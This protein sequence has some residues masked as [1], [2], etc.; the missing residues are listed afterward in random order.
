MPTN[1][2]VPHTLVV[3]FGMIAFAYVLTWLLPAGSFETV[4]D[5]AGREVVVPGTFALRPDTPH[6]PFW[7][8][9]TVIPRGLAAGQSVIFFV[10]IIGGTLAII[11]STGAIDAAVASLLTTFGSRPALLISIG[12]LGFAAG[13]STMG[14]GTE[15]IPLAALLL[16]LSAGLR[17]DAVAVAAIMVV[18]YSLGFGTA[19]S[20]P[21]TTL[22]AQQLAS[23]P[24]IS[25]AG[26]RIAIFAPFL[27]LGF[28]HV[29]R[30]AKRVREMPSA[31]L[32]ADIPEAQ[33]GAPGAHVEISRLHVA[34]LWMT[35]G[36]LALIFWGII[37]HDWYLNELGGVFV[38]LAILVGL[39][40]RQSLDTMAR[41]FTAGAASLTGT[42][43]LIGFA[44]SI[45]LMLSDGRVLHTLVSGLAAPLAEIGGELSAVGMLFIHITLDFFIPS[46]TAQAYLTI[47][48]MAPIGDLVG[49]SRQTAVLAFQMGDGVMNMIAP[50]NATLMGILGICGIP[51]G[52]WLRFIWPLIAQLIVVASAALIVAVTIGYQ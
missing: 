12:M 22:V 7:S 41:T 4:V 17:L 35:L 43:L 52:R 39:V 32:V 19:V 40:A 37:E 24:P 44:R 51:Y 46:G 48:L 47:P 6:L 27:L 8:M 45:E 28:R 33:P 23:L 42:A 18:G 5:A 20:S 26:F 25:G 1:R 38:A 14:L 36:A 9:F 34:V 15:Y 21:T 2:K 10:L 3:L 50:A 16:M 49:V 11:R 30:Y 13:S 31:S 29:W